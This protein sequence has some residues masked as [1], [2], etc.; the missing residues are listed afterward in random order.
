MFQNI[1]NKIKKTI[2]KSNKKLIQRNRS[3]IL[4][5]HRVANISFDPFQMAVSEFNFE[6]QLE[7]LKDNYNVIS[8]E[9][10]IN[11]IKNKE[12]LNKYIAI[13]FD[14]GYYD[15]L[16]NALP[17][18]EKYKLPAT[19]FVSP[20][21]VLNNK[22]F[23]WDELERIIFDVE[24]SR[25]LTLKTNNNSKSWSFNQDR[26]LVLREIH[27]ILKSLNENQR[28]LII[29]QIKIWYG[30]PLE[31]R[32]EYR[33]LTAFELKKLSES[34]YVEIGAH[35]MNHVVLANETFERQEK[36]IKDS[37][38]MLEK[39]INK[40]IVSFSYPF[41]GKTDFNSTSIDIV[42]N[43]DFLC[44]MSNNQNYIDKN[45]NIFSMPRFL[46]RNWTKQEFTQK[47]NDFSIYGPE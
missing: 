37:K 33:P 1:L 16:R 15:N 39:I 25:S 46:V 30:K 19:I 38:E 4:I 35:T 40:K 10:L 8:L 18:L 42:S 47:I 13:T 20:T 31:A 41:G 29:N 2:I 45:S 5:Y 43:L 11:K 3:V 23:W 21:F 28:S 44:A 36:E 14:D 24:D 26:V 6:K 7:F 12:K 22:E 17:L 32:E 34:Q 27:Q 9:S